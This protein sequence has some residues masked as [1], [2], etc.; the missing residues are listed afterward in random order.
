MSEIQNI[1]KIFDNSIKGAL[2]S[3]QT[4]VDGNVD[5]DWE[6]FREVI[7]NTANKTLGTKKLNSKPWFNIICEVYL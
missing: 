4:T 1:G 2:Q 6:P 5:E 3:E 7:S